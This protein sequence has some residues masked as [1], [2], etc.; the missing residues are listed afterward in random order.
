MSSLQD[1]QRN[2]E[3][4]SPSAGLVSLHQRETQRLPWQLFFGRALRAGT[5]RAEKIFRGH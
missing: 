1:I 5:G 3:D 2:Y 4:L